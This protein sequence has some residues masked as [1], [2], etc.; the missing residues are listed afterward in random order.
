MTD[1]APFHR[2]LRFFT[3]RLPS[4]PD[5]NLLRLSDSLRGNLALGLDF[6]VALTVALGRHLTLRNTRRLWSLDIHIPSVP[7]RRTPLDGVDGVDPAK[8]YSRAEFTRLAGREAGFGARA[9][10]LGV[11]ALAAD[12]RTGLLK[13]EDVLAFQKGELLERVEERRKGG[14][15]QVLP[16]WRGGP[17]S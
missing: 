14:R 12:V 6:P 16:L 5:R 2:L 3:T 4:H 10:A 15:E 13:G 9:D 1:P 8:E 17:I 11:W 7:W